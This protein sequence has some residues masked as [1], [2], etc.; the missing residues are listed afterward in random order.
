MQSS[1]GRTTIT[2]TKIVSTDGLMLR[3]R[4]KFMSLGSDGLP[5]ETASPRLETTA[6]FLKRLARCDET[7][8]RRIS[9]DFL[10]CK[11]G[12]A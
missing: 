7:M 6:A 8:H 1:C 11:H 5:H 12:E 4:A 9:T 3:T 10:R 2:V